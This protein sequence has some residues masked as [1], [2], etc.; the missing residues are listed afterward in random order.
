M[1][2]IYFLNFDSK[3]DFLPTYSVAIHLSQFRKEIASRLANIVL[4]EEYNILTSTKKPEH[5]PDTTWLTG[6]L[7]EYNFLDF[8]YPEIAEF[9]EFIKE[10]FLDFLNKT[11]HAIP[12]NVYTQCWANI[13]R[14]NGR[15]ITAHHHCE[16]HTGAPQEYSY[17]S[18]NVCVQSK[19]TKTYYKNPFNETRIGIDNVDGEL[20]LFP[21]YVIHQTDANNNDSPRIS[22]AFDIITDEVYNM[23]DNNKNFRKLL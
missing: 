20:V 2:N 15:R 5:D 6:R 21:S 23:I 11:N 19:D 14:K 22:I 9:K 8:D 12:K 4:K 7:W 13:L 3:S 10:Q 18:G 16:A 17:V 1:G